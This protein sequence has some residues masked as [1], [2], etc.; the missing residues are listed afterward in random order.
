[1]KNSN[2][3]LG[4]TIATALLGAGMAFSSSIAIVGLGS[5][6][7]SAQELQPRAATAKLPPVNDG[8]PMPGF[9]ITPANTA[10][11]ITDPQNDFLSPDGVTWGVVGQSITENG[12]VENLDALF[13]VAERVDM[14]VFVSPHYYFQH[15]HEWH[16]EGT[17]ETLMHS[18]GMFD[19][20]HALSLDGFEGSGADWLESY[21]PYFEREEVVVTSPHKVYGPDSNDLA[22]QLRKAGIDKVI[23]GGMSSNLCTESH[24]R[25]LIEAGFEVMVVTDATAGAITAHYDGYAASLTNFRMI[26]SAVDNTENTVRAI[27]AAF[28]M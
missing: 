7:A 9:E 19:R 20:P 11:V 1:M 8:L 3:S 13:A 5:G 10:I 23:L 24:M 28:G 26:A 22:L 17:L 15:D 12:T 2:D 21:K 18:I 27:E 14:P 6:A 25:S 16:F 4:L